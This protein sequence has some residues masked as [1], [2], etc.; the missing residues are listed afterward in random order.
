MRQNSY[1]A[2]DVFDG[3]KERLHQF[4]EAQYHIFDESL[5]KERR[6]LLEKEGV[7]FQ[8]PFLE[9]TPVYETGMPYNEL[10]ISDKAKE[11]LELAGSKTSTGIPPRPYFHQIKA[12]EAFLEDRKDI[13][14]ATGTGSGKT[15]SFLM[16]IL[17]TLAE[18]CGKESWCQNGIRALLLYPMNALVN[19][20]MVRLRKLFGNKKIA[21]SLKGKR[22]SFPT[23]GMYTSR[24]PLPGEQDSRQEKRIKDSIE[25]AWLKLKEED[26][27]RLQSEFMIPAKD[28]L[29]EFIDSGL[30]TNP[31]DRELYTRLEMR[32]KCPDIL[33]TNYSMLEYMLLRPIEAPIFE[34]TAKWLA[35]DASNKIIIVLDE[36]HMYKGAAGAEIAFL[37]R[38]LL[39]RLKIDRSRARFI[40]TSASL[41]KETVDDFAA[42]LCNGAGEGGRFAVIEGKQIIRG[43]S[44]GAKQTPATREQFQALLDFNVENFQANNDCKAEEFHDLMKKIGSKSD[45]SLNLPVEI[46]S[47]LDSFGPASLVSNIVTKQTVST[48]EVAEAVFKDIDTVLEEKLH[49]L[50]SLLALMAYAR[51]D[52]GKTFTSIRAHFFFKG[53]SGL[54]ACINPHCSAADQTI[55]KRIL[56]KIYDAPRVACD[57]GARVYELATHRTCG[58]AFIKGY[59]V[60]DSVNKENPLLQQPSSNLFSDSFSGRR[61]SRTIETFLLVEPDRAGQSTELTYSW[62]NNFSGRFAITEPPADRKDEYLR[63]CRPEGLIK[64]KKTKNIQYDGF[65]NCPVCRKRIGFSGKLASLE[66]KGDRPFAHLV[67]TQVKLQPPTQK[68]TPENPNM[69]RKSLLFSDSRQRAAQLAK[70]IPEEL[71]KDIFRQLILKAA[72]KVENSQKFSKLDKLFFPFV[73]VCSDMNLIPFEGESRDFFGKWIN[74]CRELQEDGYSGQGLYEEL[75]GEESRFTIPDDYFVHL[76]RNIGSDDYSISTLTLGYVAF[77]KDRA[78][79]KILSVLDEKVSPGDMG[80]I[81]IIWIQNHLECFGLFPLSE[82]K[83][84]RISANDGYLDDFGIKPDSQFSKEQLEFLKKRFS[85]PVV[86]TILEQLTSVVASLDAETGRQ[87]LNAARLQIIVSDD[88]PWCQCNSCSNVSPVDWW[89]HCPLCLSS[90]TSEVVPGETPYLRSRKDFFR[91]PVIK[92]IEGK[93]KPSLLDVQEHTAQLAYKDSKEA[94]TTTENYERKFRDILLDKEKRVVDVLSSTTTMEVGID[95]GSLTAVGLSNIPP[96]RQNYQQRAGR[97]GRRGTSL[98]TV[99]TYAAN[100]PHGNYYFKNPKRII[101]GP[102]MLTSIDTGNVKIA[103]RHVRAQLIQAFFI[104]TKPPRNKSNINTVLGK[105]K[106]FLDNSTSNPFTLAQFAKWMNSSESNQ[107]CKD[108]KKWMPEG[109][110]SP[111]QI[112][113]EFIEEMKGKHAE[114]TARDHD[115]ELIEYLFAECLLPS[116]A[117]PRQLC[118]LTIEKDNRV[119]EQT[120]RSLAIALSEYAPGR[121][122]TVN[123]REYRIGAV[124]AH[125]ISDRRDDRAEPLFE[126][127]RFYAYCPNCSYSKGLVDREGNESCRICNTEFK[128]V[129]TITPEVVYPDRDGTSAAMED[130]SIQTFSTSAQLQVSAD[131]SQDWKALSGNTQVFAGQHELVMVNK[132]QAG[133]HKTVSDDYTGFQICQLCGKVPFGKQKDSRGHYRAYFT[134]G[135]GGRLCRGTFKTVYLGY[136]FMTDVLD[137]R[138][139]LSDDFRKDI[140][141]QRN[142]RVLSDAA[143]S[144][145]EVLQIAVSHKLDIDIREI[146]GGYRFGIDAAGNTTIDIFV[147]DT[148]SGGA[149]Y[150]TSVANDLKDVLAEARKVVECDCGS[151][152]HKCLRSFKNQISHANLNRFLALDLLNYIENG[153]ISDPV[154]LEK[155]R[156]ILI[157]LVKMLEIDGYKVTPSS[158]VA[159]K[160]EIKGKKFELSIVPSLFEPD[161]YNLKESKNSAV[162]TRYEI[163]NDLPGAYI[164]CTE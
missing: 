98:S 120:E 104:R 14:V 42:G 70:A 105:L 63:V 83:S 21:K 64:T 89:G 122:L 57:C 43:E 51:D 126:K 10:K 29:Q 117:F 49:A 94:N 24:T 66:T 87:S 156:E 115:P 35:S 111:K 119:V 68:E 90:Q 55:E 18:E 102:P 72:K 11:L 100:N 88:K 155:Q 92:V 37:L 74:V 135:G 71:E 26:F 59:T 152:C 78:V 86:N 41:K 123:K 159:Y 17:S 34:Q 130:S 22:D 127:A 150:V 44:F 46:Y 107:V 15:E 124:T 143:L 139:T 47:W 118:T 161:F 106:D 19:D 5:I 146:S 45:R 23:F 50:D 95:I 153:K 151:S 16:P 128:Y 58:T 134:K 149:G 39:S 108:I 40:L 113:N 48:K 36:A 125:V 82:Y 140:L 9:A 157:P 112:A 27:D 75:Q 25:N 84:A 73:E 164:Q 148:I 28:N 116:Y 154:P 158:L 99:V 33:V 136:S 160:A 61:N 138:I 60:A 80:K 91:E 96:M 131:E 8:P 97:A 30:L 7:T 132:G 3:M 81:S 142:L 93:E 162:F 163:D 54:Y 137:F 147:Y 129:K 103:Q 101:S 6:A 85:A 65:E 109:C 32:Q 145:S 69:G 1:T 62:I 13:V 53:L 110:P 4:I 12:L 76:F 144:L 67:Q 133:S 141:K 121:V 114:A 31:E 38:R 52:T 77:V 56:G 2:T 79:Q 20:Q